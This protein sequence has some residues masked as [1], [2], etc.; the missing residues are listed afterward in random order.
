MIFGP[1]PVQSQSSGRPSQRRM[2]QIARVV[3]PSRTSHFNQ[4]A[5][6]TFSQALIQNRAELL[7]FSGLLNHEMTAFYPPKLRADVW[8]ACLEH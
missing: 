6:A 4:P 7:L 8:P 2:I 5:A 1:V 3:L